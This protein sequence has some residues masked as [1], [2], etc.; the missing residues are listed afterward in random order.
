L[1]NIFW[2]NTEEAYGAKMPVEMRTKNA[3]QYSKK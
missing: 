1:D 2:D 3:Q